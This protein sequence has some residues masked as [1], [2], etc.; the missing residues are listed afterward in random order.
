MRTTTASCRRFD[1]RAALAAVAL[2]AMAAAPLVAF[3]EA[4]HSAKTTVSADPSG[5]YVDNFDYTSITGDAGGGGG[6]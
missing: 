3:A 5:D 2:A 1:V 6:G 4:T